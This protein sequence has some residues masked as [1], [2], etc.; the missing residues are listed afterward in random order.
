MVN[1]R[2]S[3]ERGWLQ[4]W[5]PFDRTW[6]LIAAREAPWE[7]R[8]QASRA[9]RDPVANKPAFIPRPLARQ[10]IRRRQVDP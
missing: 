9:R 6:L 3:R 5:D 1:V 2:W 4:V 10:P 7:W 8:D